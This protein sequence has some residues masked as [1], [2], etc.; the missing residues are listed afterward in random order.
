[1]GPLGSQAST[2]KINGADYEQLM[3]TV[4][5]CFHGQKI[6]LFFFQKYCSVRTKTLHSLKVKKKR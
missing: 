6:N 5:L 1:M 2:D 4:F 3:R